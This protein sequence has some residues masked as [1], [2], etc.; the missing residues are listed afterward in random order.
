[1]A[2]TNTVDAAAYLRRLA[3]GTLKTTLRLEKIE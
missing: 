3:H 1:M 2:A